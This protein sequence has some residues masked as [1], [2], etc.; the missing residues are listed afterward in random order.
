MSNDDY[1]FTLEA[2]Y[3]KKAKDELNENDSDRMAAVEALRKW[4]N[5]QK[6]LK[7]PSETEHLL[8]VLRHA[9]FSQIK[10]RET[11]ENV[12]EFAMKH[13]DTFH[14]L[15]L[16]DKTF[17]DIIKTGQMLYLPGYDDEGR[18][19]CVY[20]LNAYPIEKAMKEVGVQNIIKSWNASMM[21]F[22]YDEMIQ[23]N[24]LVFILDMTG[25][26]LSVISK[27]SDPKIKKYEK[28]SMKALVGRMKA[29]HYYNV[30]TLFEAFFAFYKTIM[31]KKLIDRV[32]V[33]DSLESLYTHVPKR[34]LPVEYLP[35]DYDGPS[36]GTIQDLIDEELQRL[37]SDVCK[38]FAKSYFSKEK[39]MYDETLKEKSTEPIQHFRKLNVD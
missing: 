19:V 38:N 12:A 1:K 9:K 20:R 4:L 36:A 18:K 39:Y 21:S 32:K 25:L 24:G 34:M 31:K 6:H 30:G 8:R 5:E 7:H 35:D 15:N 33:H 14:D 26:S 13:S 10:A 37:Q 27:M 2:K 22:F 29:F 17:L 3:L 23:I 11:L 28:D 16:A